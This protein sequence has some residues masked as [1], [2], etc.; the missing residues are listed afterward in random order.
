MGAPNALD[1]WTFANDLA[2]LHFGRSKWSGGMLNEYLNG[3]ALSSKSYA[4][5]Y[6]DFD[7]LMA[8]F[9]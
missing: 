2:L 7:L 4:L 8:L 1:A 3:V 5:L 6:A 9:E